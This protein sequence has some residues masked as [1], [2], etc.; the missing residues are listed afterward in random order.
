VRVLGLGYPSCF[1]PISLL[2]VRS[3]LKI[4]LS[5]ARLP[6]MGGEEACDLF[7]LLLPSS[8]EEDAVRSDRREL[9]TPQSEWFS[10]FALFPP[11]LSIPPLPRG[12]WGRL[13]RLNL[14]E[15]EPPSGSDLKLAFQDFGLHPT[16]YPRSRFL[17]PR[18]AGRTERV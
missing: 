11:L 6:H 10:L 18:A 3:S 5:R 9:L 14:P 4:G 13:A 1:S 16:L 17:Q 7:P 8:L 2:D 15:L 12:A